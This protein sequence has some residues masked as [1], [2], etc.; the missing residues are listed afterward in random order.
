MTK[1]HMFD[2]VLAIAMGTGIG[3]L[4]SVFG[5]KAVN[6]HYLRTCHDKPNHNL[7]MVDSFLG[8]TYYCIHNAHMGIRK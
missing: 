4:L 5:Q 1:N 3:L 2:S 8:D 6:Q 7:V